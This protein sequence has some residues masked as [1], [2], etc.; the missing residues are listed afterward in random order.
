MAIVLL[1]PGALLAAFAFASGGFFPDAT[2]TGAVAVLAACLVRAVFARRPLEGASSGLAVAF[3]AL[4][5]FAGWTLLSGRWSHATARAVLEYDRVLLYLAIL[6]LFGSI[7]STRD[8]ARVV[9][10]GLT[11]GALAVA[12]A[13]LAVW[14][15]PERF[16]V[17]PEFARVRLAWPTSYWNATGLLAGLAGVWCLHL[18]C[19]PREHPAVRAVGAAGLPLVAAV[20]WFSVSRGA[21]AATALGVIAYL[22]AGRSR[23]MVAGLPI[24]AAAATAGALIA[25]ATHGLADGHPGAPALADGRHAALLLAV[26]AAAAGALRVAATPLDRLAA[27]LPAPQPTV[28]VRAALAVGALAVAAAAFVAA[29]VPGR[30]ADGYDT[31]SQA[32]PVPRDLAPPERFV[33][34]RNNG[35]EELWHVSLEWGF[36]RHPWHGTGAGTYALLWARHRSDTQTVNDGHSLYLE[37]LGELGLVGAALLVTSLVAMLAAL[38][39]RARGAR[40]TWAALLAAAVVWAVHAGVDWDWE[41]PATTA[42]VFAAGGLALARRRPETPPAARRL[43]LA[44]GAVAAACAVLAVLPVLVHRSQTRL[45]AS[46]DALRAGDCPRSMRAALGSADA[47]PSR[48][49]PYEL[50]AFCD[51]RRGDDALAIRAARTAVRRDP[52]NWELRYAEALVLGAAMRDPRPAARAALER[53]PLHP[54]AREAM[55]RFDTDRPARWRRAARGLP[56]PLGPT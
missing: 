41:M 50:L 11:L 47:L 32:D 54:Y 51:S 53:N 2:A 14:L 35:R 27:R 52:G 44:R 34:L 1:G 12:V 13:A 37:Q 17:G 18:C 48:A 31:F 30:L 22:V 21:V 56:L 26:A 5:A 10:F 33:T 23:G 42:W 55:R 9:L 39:A 45:T 46:L 6:A 20:L 4:A 19:A 15:L 38:V 7:A 36:D 29:D 43:P 49:E 24:A 16:P 25:G 3:A 28:R 8:R 40:T